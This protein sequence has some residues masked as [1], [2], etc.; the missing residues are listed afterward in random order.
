MAEATVTIGQYEVTINPYCTWEDEG[1]G[2]TEAWGVWDFNQEW[3]LR[4]SDFSI[5]EVLD[6][7]GEE[8]TVNETEFDVTALRGA[9]WAKSDEIE[10]QQHTD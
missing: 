10:D 7:N 2:W 8:I 9:I 4:L 6:A 3:R 5:V 1:V